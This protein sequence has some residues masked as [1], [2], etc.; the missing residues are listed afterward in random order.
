MA[1]WTDVVNY[2]RT[3]YEVL[4]DANGWL[5]FR[6]ATEDGRS[7]QVA[8][9]HVADGDGAWVEISSPVGWADK[10]DLRVLAEKAGGAPVGGVAVVDGIALLKHAAPLAE[11]GVREE[12][13]RPLT[14]LVTQAD[15]LEREL[16][17]ADDF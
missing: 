6:L 14:L 13:V 1:S 7:Q 9:H 17:S 4:D 11:A 5:R 10:L 2:V 15:A 16:T 12:F 8:V 3:R